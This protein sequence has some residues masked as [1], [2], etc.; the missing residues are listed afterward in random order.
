MTMSADDEREVIA[1][2]IVGDEDAE[3]SVKPGACSVAWLPPL[4]AG[5][6]MM[7]QSTRYCMASVLMAR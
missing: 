6:W 1:R 3:D 7:V 2:A 5:T 4:I